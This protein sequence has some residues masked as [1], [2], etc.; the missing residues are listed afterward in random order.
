MMANLAQNTDTGHVVSALVDIQ[1][2]TISQKH[3]AE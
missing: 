2:K 3:A 1:F